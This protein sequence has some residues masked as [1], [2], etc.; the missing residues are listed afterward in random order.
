MQFLCNAWLIP[1][2]KKKNN[3]SSSTQFIAHY[4]T[5]PLGS[6][7]Q[8]IFELK[9]CVLKIPFQLTWHSIYVHTGYDNHLKNK[10]HLQYMEHVTTS[11][12]GPCGD[13]WALRSTLKNRMNQSSNIIL[14][15]TRINT[16]Y[17]DTLILEN[18]I[19]MLAYYN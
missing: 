2:K 19:H 10:N 8:N 12:C 4:H 1:K 16:R 11:F 3:N 17:G 14:W 18:L 6:C 7:F 5:H 13:N 9:Y 15:R